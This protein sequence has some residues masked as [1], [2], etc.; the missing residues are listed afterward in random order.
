[1]NEDIPSLN[2]RLEIGP[3]LQPNLLDI[4]LR[5]PVKPVLLAGDIKQAF[6]QIVI[7]ETERDALRFLWK[8]TYRAKKRRFT[9]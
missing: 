2:D 6:L 5:N 1:M 9:A 4:L 8:M 3:P 7:R